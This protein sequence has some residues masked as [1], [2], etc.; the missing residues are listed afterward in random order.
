[1]KKQYNIPIAWESY[2]TYSVEAE[3]LQEA[4][5]IALQTFLKEPDENYLTDSF[6]IDEMVYEDYQDENFDINVA[7]QNL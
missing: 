2:K 5:T 4:V 6:T 1:M 3:N 7:I